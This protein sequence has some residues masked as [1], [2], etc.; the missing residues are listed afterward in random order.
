MLALPISSLL[1]QPDV[2]ILIGNELGAI[3]H[4]PS[5]SKWQ[6]GVFFWG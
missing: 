4:P 5:A 6:A 1:A 3:D 2:P